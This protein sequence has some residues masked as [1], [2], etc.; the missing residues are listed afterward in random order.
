[1]ILTHICSNF[2]I[3]SVLGLV[4]AQATAGRVQEVACPSS[5]GP[6]MA[7]AGPSGGKY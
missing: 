2:E 7:I 3:L 6:R 1:M 5:S 4:A